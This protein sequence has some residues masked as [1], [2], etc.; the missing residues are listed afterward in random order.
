MN[1]DVWIAS[2]ASTTH[3]SVMETMTVQ[4]VRMRQLN[5]V[6]H[7]KVLLL[8]LILKCPVL[9]MNLIVEQ[10][11]FDVI[12]VIVFL[13]ICNVLEKP[14]A[15]T[16]QTR[17][18]AVSITIDSVCRRKHNLQKAW[19]VIVLNRETRIYL[20]LCF[21]LFVFQVINKDSNYWHIQPFF[22]IMRNCW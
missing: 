12:M 11:N 18:N 15:Q 6:E 13:V 22:T 10:I 16:G 9:L 21:V 1:L 7:W 3:G 20:N 8:G 19:Y 17:W 14:N 2:T 4:M 5:N